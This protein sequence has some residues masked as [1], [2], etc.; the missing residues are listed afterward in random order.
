ML[1]S[2]DFCQLELRILTHLCQDANL[3]KIMN[4]PGEDIFKK[5]AANWWKVQ[6]TKVTD[7]QRLQAKQICYGIIYGMGTKALSESLEV[8][9]ETAAKLAMEFHATY[10]GIKRYSERT[11]M[12]VRDLGYCQTLVGRR[13]YLPS[14]QS[15]NSSERSQ[16]ERQ[17]LN[18]NIQGTASDVVKNAILRMDREL[19]RRQLS[20]SCHLVLHL[21]DEL[22]YEVPADKI[23]QAAQ[24]LIGSM[25]NCVKLTVP[26][27]VKI[28]AGTNWGEME[29]F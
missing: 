27:L 22:F 13:R 19:S 17:A 3:L 24:V 25:E 28:K 20:S 2:A 15:E 21:H 11:M 16:A 10:P 4:S 14:I 12:N 26:L 6:E 23:N 8:D 1:L 5:V 7:E 18:T 29:K 9:E